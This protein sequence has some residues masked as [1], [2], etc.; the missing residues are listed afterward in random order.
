MDDR[1]LAYYQQEL[2]W[3]REMGNEFAQRYPAVAGRLGMQEGQI[4]DPFVERLLEGTAFLTSR[5]QLKMDA[6]YPQL[7][8]QLLEVLYPNYLAPVPSMAVVELQPDEGKGDIS[9]GFTIPRGTVMDSLAL[10]KQGMTCR[11]STAHEVVLQPLRIEQVT[12]GPVPATVAKAGIRP[13]G[14]SSALRITLRCFE[15]VSLAQMKCDRIMFYLCADQAPARELLELL[16]EHT[17]HILCSIDGDDL[18][19]SLLDRHCLRHEGFDRDQALLP[20]DLR[21]L[22]AYRLLQEYFFIPD[23]FHFFSISGLQPL[24]A[25][26]GRQQQFEIILLLGKQNPALEQQVDRQHLAL[27]CT[28]VINLFPHRADRF[29]LDQQQSEHPLVADHVRPDD[30]EIYSVSRIRGY[31]ADNRCQRV[32]RQMY[33]PDDQHGDSAEPSWFSLRRH[34]QRRHANSGLT[35][36]N[37]YSASAVYI[38]LTGGVSTPDRYWQDSLCALEA[39]IICTNAGLPLIFAQQSDRQLVMRESFPVR[40]IVIRQGPTPPTSAMADSRDSW[41]LVNQLNLNLSSLSGKTAEHSAA[42]LRQLLAFHAG[43]APAA[44]RQLSGIRHCTLTAVNRLMAPP[45]LYTGGTA[46]A[47]SVDEQVF[48]GAGAWLLGSVLARLFSQS[49]AINSFTETTLTDASQN[50]IGCWAMRSGEQASL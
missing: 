39:D 45:G 10:K 44:A 17:Q 33:A 1:L 34:P 23:R 12:L 20:A 4:G 37:G 24:L 22:E 3:L 26:A 19:C 48:A 31:G 40:H 8:R 18:T 16:M 47:I 49:A 35:M 32:F 21:N 9:G 29:M 43:Q 15:N 25:R 36:I 46:V 30:F 50:I 14:Q 11:F 41:Q 27:H 2:A 6:G 42:A 7:S 13:S 5:I 28:P 38:T